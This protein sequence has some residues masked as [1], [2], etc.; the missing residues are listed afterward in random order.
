MVWVLHQTTPFSPSGVHVQRKPSFFRTFPT[1]CA[2]V[3]GRLIMRSRCMGRQRFDSVHDVDI[4]VLAARR[5]WY[6]A[7]ARRALEARRSSSLSFAAFSAGPPSGC[8]P[9]EP[10]SPGMLPASGRG[11]PPGQ[12]A[13]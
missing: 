12:S 3:H 9:D 13:S 6:Q 4:A 7:D 11:T 2:C 5:R 1:S 10:A 8:T